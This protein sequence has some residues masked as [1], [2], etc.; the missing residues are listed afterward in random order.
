MRSIM[1]LLIL[2]TNISLSI[3]AQKQICITIDDLPTVSD[4]HQTA[5]SR[6]S[7]TRRLLSHLQQHQV[8]AIGFVIGEKLMN[9]SVADQNQLK[10]LVHWLDAGFDL[11]NHTFTHQ[12]YNAMSAVMYQRDISEGEKLLKPLIL[13]YNKQLHYFRHPYL[14]RGNTIGKMDS[15]T[16]FLA[17]SGYKEAPVTMNN[18]DYLFSAAYEKALLKKDNVLAE[19][20][21]KQYIEYMMASVHFYESQADSL[22]HHPIPHVLLTHANTINSI[23]LGTL[24]ARL[25]KEGY[26]FVTMEKVLAH[27]AY[28]S[29]DRFIGP[30]GI[31]WIQRWALTQGK[32]ESFCDGE[33]EIPATI[34]NP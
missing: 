6:D 24:L 12:G 5:G 9:G 3:L 34:I 32:P 29:Q 8:P 21:G 15:L 28:R 16:V 33:P 26:Q 18:R 11:G 2:L 27:P 30:E 7:L 31:S 4:L 19:S 20:I 25:E 23:F 10:L 14:A 22:F 1:L 17:K 13:R